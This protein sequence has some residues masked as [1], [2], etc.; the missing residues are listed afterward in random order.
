MGTPLDRS[1]AGADPGLDGAEGAEGAVEIRGFE[2]ADIPAA[3]V[4]WREAHGV[5]LRDADEPVAVQRYLQRNAGTSFV[6]L[7]GARVIGTVLCG[8]DGRRG[9]L[10]HLAV[11]RAYRGRGIARALAARALEAL[12]HDGIDKCHLTVVAGNAEARAFWTA[13]GW[14]LRTDVVLMSCTAP[15][16]PNA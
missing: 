7:F 11:A 2:P 6:A 16:S 15:G 8:H 9:Y 5:V 13:T 4:L 10:Y 1:G 14:Q 3:L 12:R